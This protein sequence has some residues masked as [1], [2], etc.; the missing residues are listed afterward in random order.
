MM[1]A[2]YEP[3]SQI[4]WSPVFLFALAGLAFP[5][6]ALAYA[7]WFWLLGRMP[8]GRANAF[9]FLTPFFALALGIGFFGERAG[10]TTIL[11]LVLAAIGIVLVERCAVPPQQ[12]AYKG[13]D[14]A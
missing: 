3:P 1:A 11:G 7:L 12:G 4:Q 10:P 5:G 9:M 13:S 14:G 8:L 2:V 6:T